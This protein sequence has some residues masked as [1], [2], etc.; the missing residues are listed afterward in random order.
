M[1]GFTLIEL[2]IVLAIVAILT[3]LALP[4]YFQ[5]IDSAK[6][7][8]LLQNLRETREVIDKFYGDNGRYPESL[9]ELV[10]KKYLRSV[11]NDP[12]ADSSSAWIIEPPEEGAKGNV[13]NLR[14]GA[15]GSNKD[16]KSWAE[17]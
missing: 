8:V 12:V 6:E 7:T 9:E 10:E 17:F 1:R 4:R 15:E 16:G 11:P 14:S 3:T 5:Y 2:L 13:Y